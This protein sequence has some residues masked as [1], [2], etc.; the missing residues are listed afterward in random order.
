MK[1]GT[2]SF[3]PLHGFTLVELLVVIAIIGT[4]VGLLL[5][6]VQAAR[7]AARQST[8]PNNL[9]QIGLAAQ[10]YH[11]AKKSFPPGVKSISN[12]TQSG[13]AQT[14]WSAYA[15]SWSVFVLPFME[16]VTL[17]DNIAKL[18][19]NF[20]VYGSGLT[21]YGGSNPNYG[22]IPLK[23]FV[24]PSCPMAAINPYPHRNNAKSN[25]KA[26]LGNENPTDLSGDDAGYKKTLAVFSGS[27]AKR[28]LPRSLMA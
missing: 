26:L 28:P 18:N 27:I 6:A 25:Y 9:K 11:D 20:D 3:R 5:P 1:E 15:L 12:R 21:W 22:Q 19:N 14:W 10:N 24:C 2:P 23:S 8:C 4:L 16:E 17:Y 7:E 13:S